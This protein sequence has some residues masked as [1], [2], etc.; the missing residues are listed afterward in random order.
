M[1][2]TGRAKARTTYLLPPIT[3]EIKFSQADKRSV[4]ATV[5]VTSG[6]HVLRTRY[7]DVSFDRWGDVPIELEEGLLRWCVYFV[8]FE[9]SRRA[10]SEN[11]KWIS[12]PK[13]PEW[14][15]ALMPFVVS[16][17]EGSDLTTA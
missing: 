4:R 12:Y 9:K 15:P 7:I 11:K 16:A 14:P 1:A 10:E 2:D 6:N 17:E 13:A 8:G 3:L 5:I